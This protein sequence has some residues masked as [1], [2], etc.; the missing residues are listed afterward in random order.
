MKTKVKFLFILSIISLS[1]CYVYSN[2]E[3]KPIINNQVIEIYK[4]DNEIQPTSIVQAVEKVY[5]SVVV[6]RSYMTNG[7]SSGS[8]VIVG[9]SDR[10]SYII[11]CHHVIEGA[12]SYEVTLSND[13]TYEATLIGG[14]P[15]TDIAVIAIEK[16]NLTV[17][18]FINDSS[19]IS[20]GSTTIAIGN[21][22]G[23]LGNSVTSGIVSSL[24][25]K[26]T[27]ADGTKH[28]LIQTDAAINSGN[29]GGGL[30]N[31]AGELIGIVSAKYSAS[32]VEG[33]GFAVPANTASYVMK[34][35]CTNGYVSGRYN[36]GITITD[37]QYISGGFFGQTYNVTYINS[38]DEDGCAYGLLKKEDI[39]VSIQT[40]YSDVSKS[41]LSLET[42]SCAED[43]YDFI[44]EANLTV[45]DKLIFNVKR[46]GYSGTTTKVEVLLTQYIYS[47]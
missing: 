27:M 25:R 14:D 2:K 17:A 7:Y 18:S 47:N 5:D 46:N 19:T 43:V 12:T 44:D 29:S 11:T 8:G 33:L 22:L 16:T 40:S 15:T 13:E 26:I 4:Q 34:E 45:N 31:I 37:G 1:G 36:L 32:G 35:L 28:E 23:T 38:I 39:L 21:P 24:N 6:L 42:I 41:N 20:L 10:F 3:S 30:F 9:E